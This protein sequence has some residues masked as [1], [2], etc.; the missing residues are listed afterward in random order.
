MNDTKNTTA[1]L[2]TVRVAN[3]VFEVYWD[4]VKK[5][6]EILNGCNGSSGGPNIY[7]Y[8]VN[9]SVRWI[10]SLQATK[11]LLARKFAERSDAPKISA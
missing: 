7:G 5:K 2:Q 3:G 1:R 6:G 10:G 8:S 11:R 9:G 4:G